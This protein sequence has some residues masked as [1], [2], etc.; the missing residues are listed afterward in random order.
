MRPA[1]SNACKMFIHCCKLKKKSIA[2]MQRECYCR[3]LKGT[4]I[5]D[6]GLEWF[7]QTH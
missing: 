1:A 3:I 7:K 5:K 4:G 6:S 2:F